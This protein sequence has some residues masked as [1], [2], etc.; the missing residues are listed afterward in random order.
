M[1]T[2]GQTTQALKILAK[3]KLTRLLKNLK[4]SITMY[5][6]YI[7]KKVKVFFWIKKFKISTPELIK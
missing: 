3:E 7:Y 2:L 6:E 5:T 4:Q 1:Q